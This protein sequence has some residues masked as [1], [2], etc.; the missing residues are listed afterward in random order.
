[1][2]SAAERSRHGMNSNRWL[3]LSKVTSPPS[4]HV[5]APGSPAYLTRHAPDD[6]PLRHPR[7]PGPA[8]RLR[9]GHGQDAPP[10]HPHPARPADHSPQADLPEQRNAQNPR[11]APLLLTPPS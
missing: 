9:P 2:P 1:M 4:D 11:P 3:L 10:V 6:D 7:L 8:H 5:T